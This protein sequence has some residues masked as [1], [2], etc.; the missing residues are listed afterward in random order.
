M[1][2][3]TFYRCFWGSLGSLWVSRRSFWGSLRWIWGSPDAVVVALED[4][5]AT[6]SCILKP[7]NARDLSYLCTSNPLLYSLPLSSESV[8][9]MQYNNNKIIT[10]ILSQHLLFCEIQPEG[11]HL[12]YHT[13]SVRTTHLSHWD[14][15]FAQRNCHI[16]P[17]KWQL[18]ENCVIC[19]G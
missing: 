4:F 10:C 11:R 18:V 3:I 5:E 14:W 12:M 8:Q 17:F 2:E 7:T 6:V 15:I 13:T 1:H 9:F 19:D 16:S